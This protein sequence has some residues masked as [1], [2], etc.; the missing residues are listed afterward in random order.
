MSLT[1]TDWHTV[2]DFT[3]P[4]QPGGGLPLGRRVPSQAQS[5]P[6]VD[7]DLRYFNKGGSRLD[8]L[9]VINRGIE[10]A[11]DVDLSVPD[12]AALGLQRAQTPIGKTP[13]GGKSVT[14]DVENHN[15]FFGGSDKSDVFDVRVSARTEDG[16]IVVKDV[17]M[18]L[19]G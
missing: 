15:R 14:L 7:I 1:G 11:Y 4:E 12:T 2:G 9:Q 16:R 5:R 6:P 10:T 17:F 8:K 18:D 3:A 13:G 19:N